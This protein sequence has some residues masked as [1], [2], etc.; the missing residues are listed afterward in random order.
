MG[1]GRIARTT[2]MCQ[3]WHRALAPGS[4]SGLTMAKV[5]CMTSLIDGQQVGI[6]IGQ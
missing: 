5:V 4:S 1:R 2:D 6:V 3:G